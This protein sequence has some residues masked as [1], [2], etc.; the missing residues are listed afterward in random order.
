[1][2]DDS[3][4]I[5]ELLRGASHGYDLFNSKLKGRDPKTRKMVDHLDKVSLDDVIGMADGAIHAEGGGGG[6]TASAPLV[7]TRDEDGGALVVVDT[8]GTP[9]SPAHVGEVH[10]DKR[11][12]VYD[13]ASNWNATVVTQHNIGSV[14]V[15]RND[16]IVQVDISFSDGPSDESGGDTAEEHDAGVE[17]REVDESHTEDEE[18]HSGD[19][20][21]SESNQSG[22]PTLSKWLD[23]N[24]W[25][26]SQ[27][28]DGQLQMA[29]QMFGDKPVDELPIGD[30]LGGS[31]MPGAG[32]TDTTESLA[33]EIDEQIDDGFDPLEDEDGEE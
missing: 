19:S 6:E 25:L 16:D 10:E 28:P 9:V 29:R 24:E 21:A 14:D 15:S 27:L 17:A 11:I 13:E 8:T 18:S 23:Q 20:E 7:E 33:D 1:M 22:S 2:A 4:S 30:F 32:D 5:R 12:Q 3:P 31:G 26:A